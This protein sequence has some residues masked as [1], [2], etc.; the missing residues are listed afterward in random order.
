MRE[1]DIMD[2]LAK[3]KEEEETSYGSPLHQEKVYIIMWQSSKSGG[4]YT[5]LRKSIRGKNRFLLGLRMMGVDLDEVQ[6][7][8]Q[9]KKW[10]PPRK[11][12]P[13]KEEN[14]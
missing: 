4:T 2:I 11:T 5:E 7:F 6:V 8:E 12:K 9:D 14:K 10:I 3:E 13:K 1:S